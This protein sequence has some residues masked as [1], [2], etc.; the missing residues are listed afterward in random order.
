MKTTLKQNELK[1]TIVL[2]STIE[3]KRKIERI[4]L[5]NNISK[6]D[7]IRNFIRNYEEKE[8]QLELV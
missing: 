7:V 6:S 4:A 1:T 2:R 5:K 8:N 3:E